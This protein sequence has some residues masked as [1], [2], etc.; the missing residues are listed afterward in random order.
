MA[1]SLRFIDDT[2]SPYMYDIPMEENKHAYSA[3]RIQTIKRCR[4]SMPDGL[5]FYDRLLID[6]GEMDP[7]KMYPPQNPQAFKLLISE[8]LENERLDRLK[9]YSFL[10]YLYRDM[11]KVTKPGAI[12]PTE[13]II[14]ALSLPSHF[15]TMM[16]G[17]YDLDQHN[18]EEAIPALTHPSV[19]PNYTRQI[20]VLL[21]TCNTN[22]LRGAQLAVL[23]MQT[24][25]HT[26]NESDKATQ[27][28]YFNALK[29]VSIT[30]AYRYLRTLFPE[31]LEHAHSSPF[32]IS[33]TQYALSLPSAKIGAG[34]QLKGEKKVD[35]AMEFLQLPFSEE[36]QE[37]I[38]EFLRVHSGDVAKDTVILMGMMSGKWQEVFEDVGEGRGEGVK[39]VGGLTWNDILG[40]WKESAKPRTISKA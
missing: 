8:I 23:F 29:Q 26:T 39:K 14:K 25:A 30:G 21:T 27:E 13:K 31:G 34:E 9:K 3:A 18:F 28:V 24:A 40:G 17:F 10:Y 6:L 38:R 15:V 11:D 5:L 20:L 22:H 36:E 16:D 37:V 19:F 12:L 2:V 32:L 35:S 4:N 1:P 33:L 7:R